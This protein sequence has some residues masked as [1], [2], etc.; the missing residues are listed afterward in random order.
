MTRTGDADRGATAETVEISGEMIRLGQL[1][2]LTGIAGIGSDVKAI[3]ATAAITV[4][5]EPEQR[6]GRQLHPGDVVTLDGHS[7]TLARRA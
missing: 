4:N 7:V 1:L 5:G 6:R 2:K 3:L